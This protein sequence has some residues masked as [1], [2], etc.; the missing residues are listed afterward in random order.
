[1]NQEKECPKCLLWGTGLIFKKY[2]NQIKFHEACGNLEIV[3]VTSNEKVFVKYRDITFIE[4][5]ELTKIEFDYIICMTGKGAYIQI[6]EEAQELG[7]KKCIFSYEI[8][9]HSRVE[10][11]KYMELKKNTPSIFSN[12]CWGGVTYSDL[13]LEFKSPMINMFVREQDYLKLLGNPKQYMSYS[14]ELKECLYT[15]VYNRYYPVCKCGDIELHFNH[16]A[17]FEEAKECWERRKKRIDWNNLF[18]MMY[19]ENVEVAEA[20]NKLP[21]PRK[22]CFVPFEHE[23]ES[24]VYVPFRNFEKMKERPFWEVVI[25]MAQGKWEFYNPIDLLM[26]C[27][28]RMP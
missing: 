7:L 20:F 14:L 10:L 2:I 24:L 26:E 11:H 19:T 28:I 27:K 6:V 25:G 21:Y 16:Y 8:F 1:M 4:K 3:G 23:A 5:Q 17:S 22:V 15:E 12:N 13:D 9:S 18:V